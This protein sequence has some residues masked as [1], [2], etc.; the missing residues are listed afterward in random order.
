LENKLKADTAHVI[1]ELNAAGLDLKIISGDNG[2]TTV[3]C[4]RECNIFEADLTV[5][6]VDYNKENKELIIEKVD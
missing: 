4:A 2:L 3:Q 1:R 6:M 5:L